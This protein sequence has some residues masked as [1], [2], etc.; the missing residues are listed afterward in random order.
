MV[1]PPLTRSC[2][3]AM[4]ALTALVTLALMHCPSYS[5]LF[6]RALP[7]CHGWVSNTARHMVFYTFGCARPA[8]G[9]DLWLCSVIYLCWDLPLLR[10]CAFYCYLPATRGKH[11]TTCLFIVPNVTVCWFPLCVVPLPNGTYCQPA[12]LFCRILALTACLPYPFCAPTACVLHVGQG[13]APTLYLPSYTLCITLLI[14]CYACWVLL[15][16]LYLPL[17][18]GCSVF[19]VVVPCVGPFAG[20]CCGTM[21]YTLSHHLPYLPYSPLFYLLPSFCSLVSFP[22]SHCSPQLPSGSERKTLPLPVHTACTF[23]V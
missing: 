7:P 18:W 17:L 15:Q 16:Y 9:V 10:F 20:V 6:C 5:D 4:P 12:L 11:G 2:A 8:P 14:P 22:I 21:P 3:C 13:P 1:T 23:V 19:L